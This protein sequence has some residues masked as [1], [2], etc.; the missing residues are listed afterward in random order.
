MYTPDIYMTGKFNVDDTIY[1]IVIH[2]LTGE[3]FFCAGNT[4]EQT[5][6][7]LINIFSGE[8]YRDDIMQYDFVQPLGPD[9]TVH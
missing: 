6:L 5:E 8:R 3:L 7:C 1:C 2:K 4:N 9:T